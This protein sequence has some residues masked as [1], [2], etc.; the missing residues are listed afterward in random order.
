[1]PTTLV[2]NAFIV[3]FMLSIALRLLIFVKDALYFQRRCR[4]TITY[5]ALNAA[6]V[7]YGSANNLL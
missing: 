5:D 4:C 1:M 7:E 3:F 2:Y 6:V